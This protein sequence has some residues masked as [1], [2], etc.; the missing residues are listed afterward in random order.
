[1]R[2]FSH[3]R[4]L[5][6]VPSLLAVAIFVSCSDD[7][8]LP[9]GSGNSS[10]TAGTAGTAASGGSGGS[11]QGGSSAGNGGSAGK[12]TGGSAGNVAGGTAG[13]G[14]AAGG[15]G[16][17][18]QGEGGE[19]NGV[20]G[21]P[22]E[23]SCE[24]PFESGAGGQG[25]GGAEGGAPGLEPAIV[26]TYTFEAPG[27]ISGWE[28]KGT[29]SNGSVGDSFINRT[30]DEGASCPGALAL[31]VPFSAYG[32]P[33]NG[34]AQANFN[35]DWTGRSTLHIAIK[36]ADPGTGNLDYLNGAQI[37]LQTNNWGV[38]TSKFVVGTELAD[39]E[40]HSYELDL[41]ELDLAIVN[42]VGVQL[43]A[44]DAAPE[45]G[46]AAPLATVLYIDDLWLE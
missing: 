35:L 29:P 39:F 23:P 11:G 28:A 25:G 14:G 5:L 43:V 34:L 40:W 44:K 26:N 32:D 46:P 30:L 2:N 19:D 36:I 22:G 37:Y 7:S 27:S 33:M 42:Q 20:A 8:S 12:N 31:T 21:A 4:S 17:D 9:S 6:L 15:T 45:G 10:G 3:S 13:S 24:L 41:S 16:G 18:D 1:M 38:Y